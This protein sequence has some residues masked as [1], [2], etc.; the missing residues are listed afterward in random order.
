[1]AGYTHKVVRVYTVTFQNRGG[2]VLQA[3]QAYEAGETP[4]YS[5]ET[6][7]FEDSESAKLYTFRAWKAEGDE[8]EYTTS[9]PAVTD[10]DIIYVAQYD[11]VEVLEISNSTPIEKD[12]E[13]IHTVVSTT[14]ILKT[15]GHTLT[16]TNLILEAEP[17]T[18]GQISSGSDVEVTGNVYFDLKLNTEARHWH[19][20]G[21]PWN[22]DVTEHALTE[23]ETGR[24][25]VVGRDCE[26]VWYNGATR[27]SQGPGAHC[28]EYL[29]HYTEDGQPIDVMTPGK[30]YMI[31]FTRSVKTVRFTKADGAD[32]FFGGTNSV[33]G[34]TGEDGGW[35]ALANPMAYHA[36]LNAGPTVGYVHDGGEIGSDGYTPYDINGTKYIVGKMVYVQATEN[37][38]IVVA[39]AGDADEMTI[40]S[41]PVRRAKATYKQYL[42]LTDYYDVAIT[43]A[44]EA[45]TSHVYVLPEEDKANEYVIGH[46]L[47]QFSMNYTKPQIWVNRYD[48]KLALNTTAP[49]DGVTEFPVSLYAPAA[50]EYTI[51]NVQSPE[52]DGNNAIYLTLDGKAIWNLSNGAYTLSLEEGTT[53][54][55]GLRI[56]ANSP[57]VVTGIDEAVVN[58]QGETRKVLI[59]DKVFIIRG[60]NIYSIDG[61]MVK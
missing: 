5:G 35:N 38:S 30:G 61:Q 43:D 15:N 21:V 20:F 57:Q 53:K 14:G 26:I 11:E 24:T 51:S 59:N 10:H 48:T 3:A 18:S 17:G 27:A 58:A 54:G 31:A 40:H 45:K 23:V 28:W 29:K 6:P 16:T 1:M 41:A 39:P 2:A 4:T 34:G 7:T 55:Y 56:S 22:V 9:F 8:N 19:A 46:D 33:T 50:G 49:V 32:I 13:V 42:S 47:S 44:E 60:N 52:T 37:A 36:T 12:I 25:L